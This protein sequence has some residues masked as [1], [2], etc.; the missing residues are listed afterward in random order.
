MPMNFIGA[1][2]TL[3]AGSGLA[4]VLEV[5]FGDVRKMLSGEKFPMNMRAQSL[6]T[7]ELLK[8]IVNQDDVSSHDDL[9]TVLE[10]LTTR[11]RFAKLWI[12]RLIK[13]VLTMMLFVKVER[14]V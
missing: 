7:D 8:K 14:G 1:A 4:E 10:D 13:T 9:L 2:G 6:L 12:D 5:V 11:S 3:M